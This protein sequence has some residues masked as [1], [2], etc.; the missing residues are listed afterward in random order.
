MQQV[1]GHGCHAGAAASSTASRRP[2]AIVFGRLLQCRSFGRC[3][4]ALQAKR[5]V[6]Q[7]AL[8]PLLTVVSALPRSPASIAIRSERSDRKHRFGPLALTGLRT[9]ASCLTAVR[10][11]CFPPETLAVQSSALA[12]QPIRGCE[13]SGA[14]A[15]TN[16]ED[17]GVIA[18]HLL[19][20]PVWASAS[21]SRGHGE[22]S[23]N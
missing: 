14:Q 7:K 2:I 13:H 4:V 23:R 22:T 9:C 15:P 3:T 10:G 20:Q 8:S 11:L 21:V 16:V 6:T 19:P 5:V 18:R 1:T 12:R 17:A